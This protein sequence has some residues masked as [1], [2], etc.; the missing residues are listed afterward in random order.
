MATTIEKAECVDAEADDAEMLPIEKVH[1]PGAKTI[2]EVANFLGMEEKQTLKALLFVTYNEENEVDG[3]VA[4][5]LRGDRAVS[6]THLD[7]YKRQG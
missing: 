1:T 7:V 5:F 4:A 3:Y 2:E 6:Y